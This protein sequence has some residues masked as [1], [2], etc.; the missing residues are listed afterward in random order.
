MMFLSDMWFLMSAKAEGED[1]FLCFWLRRDIY[2]M[3]G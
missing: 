3:V 2:A 1:N